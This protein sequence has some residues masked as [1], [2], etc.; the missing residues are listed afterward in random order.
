MHQ[1]IYLKY[2]GYFFRFLFK[3]GFFS[4]SVIRFSDLQISKKVFQKTILS[5]KFKFPANKFQAQD[6]FLE[7]VSFFLRFGDLKKFHRTF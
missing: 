5:L 4:E 6:S 7:Y 2:Y 1:V 3:G